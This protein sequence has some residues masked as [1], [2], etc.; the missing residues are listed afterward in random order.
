MRYKLFL[1]PAPNV[2]LLN[3]EG[4]NV[5][6]SEEDWESEANHVGFSIGGD[7]HLD[8]ERT[9]YDVIQQYHDQLEEKVLEEQ[10]QIQQPVDLSG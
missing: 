8:Q 4:S 6:N 1:V 5:F 10:Q 9:A 2:Q 3:H 7:T